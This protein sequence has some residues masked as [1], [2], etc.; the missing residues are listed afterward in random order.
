LLLRSFYRPEPA[1]YA[2]LRDITPEQTQPFAVQ[3]E[4][5]QRKAGAQPVVV[6]A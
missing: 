1:V 4:I 6:L 2:A 3:I 5:D